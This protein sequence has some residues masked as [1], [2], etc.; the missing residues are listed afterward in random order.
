[1]VDLYQTGIIITFILVISG[2]MFGVLS[3]IDREDDGVDFAIPSAFNSMY[4]TETGQSNIETM[5]AA[6]NADF[7]SAASSSNLATQTILFG[8]VL[9]QGAIIVAS[10]IV[11]A[12]T[13]W[14]AIVDILFGFAADTPIEHLAEPIKIVLSIIIIYTII[15][16]LGDMIRSLP[17]F[18]GR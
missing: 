3:E 17:F 13:S 12:F 7:N 18:G 15:K 14:F 2:S 8:N 9:I 5:I 1:M 6:L 11:V 4:S 16:F 10:L